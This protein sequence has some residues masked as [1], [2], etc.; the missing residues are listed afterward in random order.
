MIRLIKKKLEEDSWYRESVCKRATIATGLFSVFT[1]LIGA[2]EWITY[3]N[4][5]SYVL[6]G[7]CLMF[8]LM[9]IFIPEE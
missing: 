6:L 4:G 2:I 3:R 7:L 1:G 5:T 9:T 8:V